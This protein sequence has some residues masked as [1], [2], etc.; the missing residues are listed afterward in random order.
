MKLSMKRAAKALSFAH[1]AGSV[2]RAED[3][4]EKKREDAR[5]AEDDKKA[6]R[7]E[8]D[9]N[10]DDLSTS[11]DGDEDKDGDKKGK[12]AKA[13]AKA[14]SE[15][16]EEDDAYD[17]TTDDDRKDEEDEDDEDDDREIEMRGKSAVAHGRK[18]E[19]ARCA[20]IFNSEAAGRNPQ[21]AAHFAFN[22]NLSAAQAIEGLKVVPANAA[23]PNRA[24]SNPAVG[25]GGQRDVNPQRAV[26]ESWDR[27]FAS[28]NP[29]RAR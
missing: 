15:G 29:R 28:A 23:R 22:T 11:G 4:E 2:S 12:K 20:A 10:G 26:A 25:A 9:D 18:L 7:A 6:K 13:K 17:D 19:R 5:R 16:D 21:L 27:A 1:L 8:G 3:D 14:D 24:A